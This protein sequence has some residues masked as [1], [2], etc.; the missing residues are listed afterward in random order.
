VATL[1]PPNE[2]LANGEAPP[3]L[4]ARLTPPKI[5]DVPLEGDEKFSF[6]QSNIQYWERGELL[7]TQITSKHLLV[8]TK[9][10]ALLQYIFRGLVENSYGGLFNRARSFLLLV[11]FL[12]QLG[13]LVLSFSHDCEDSE[14]S[15][16]QELQL[17][18]K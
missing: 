12:W 16:S 10:L 18:E 2:K 9:N 15:I 3:P 13:I 7:H 1:V 5:D 8:D 17:I 14:D 4:L 11:L 6:L